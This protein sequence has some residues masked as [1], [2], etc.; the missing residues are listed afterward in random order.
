[1]ESTKLACLERTAH[2][3]AGH[4]V[5]AFFYQLPFK[6]VTIEPKAGA[7]GHIR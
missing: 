7:L 5:V 1:M 3:E 4:A 6:H 2:H